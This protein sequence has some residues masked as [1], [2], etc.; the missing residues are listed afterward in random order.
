MASTD[1]LPLTVS[2]PVWGKVAY[3]LGRN[4]SYDAAKRGDFPTVEIGGSKRVP[5]RVALKTLVGEGAV[6]ISG[7]LERFR[8]AENEK[9]AA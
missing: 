9:N 1:D 7:I 5:L 3:G 6:D 2:V 8:K 4:A